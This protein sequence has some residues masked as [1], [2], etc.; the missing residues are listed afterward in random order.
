MTD[1]GGSTLPRRQIGKLLRDGRSEVGFT[2]EQVAA[3]MQWSKSKLSRIEK[4]GGGGILREVDMRELGRILEFDDEKAEALVAL[5]QQIDAKCWWH[6]F[7]DV[8][9]KSLNMYVGLESAAT[10]LEIFRPDIVPGLFQTRDYARALDRTY[11]SNESDEELER[12]VQLRI[13]RQAILTRRRRPVTVELILHESVLRT[14]V[15]SRRVMAAQLRYIA[16]LGTRENVTVLILPSEKGFPVGFPVGP[17][18]I[19]NFGQDTNGNESS[20]PVVYVE[21]LTGDMYLEREQDTKEYRRASA[22]LRQAAHD[23]VASRGLLRRMAR[24]YEA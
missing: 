14:V 19:L 1:G 11:F 17:F 24:E 4:G 6:T 2:L 8:I 10:S 20:P 18:V 15:G 16:D 21:A 5:A 3:M 22:I 23:A 9:R 7:D 12:R 13:T